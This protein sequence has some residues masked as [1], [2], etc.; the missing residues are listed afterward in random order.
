M[1]KR[2]MEMNW[3]KWCKKGSDNFKYTCM[4]CGP[5]ELSCAKMGKDALLQHATMEKT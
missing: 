1:Q 3:K 2:V 4:Y 5:K